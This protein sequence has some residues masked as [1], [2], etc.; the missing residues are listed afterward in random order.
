MFHLNLGNLT[1]FIQILEVEMF[2]NAS[3]FFN[4]RSE[5]RE[6]PK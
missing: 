2:C 4:V 1:P 5:N 3:L 6:R